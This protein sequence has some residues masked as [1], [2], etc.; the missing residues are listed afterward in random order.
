MASVATASPQDSK[1]EH[2]FLSKERRVAGPSQAASGIA[3]P[4][5]WGVWI[6]LQKAAVL[7]K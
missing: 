2:A 5:A 7:F 3:V 4:L 6:T 1:P